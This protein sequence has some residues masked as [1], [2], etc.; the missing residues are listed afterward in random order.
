MEY[1]LNKIDP[2]LRRQVNEAAKEG[3][4]HGADHSLTVNKDRKQE[5]K[6]D[7]QKKLESKKRI[8]IDAENNEQIDLE[9]FTDEDISKISSKGTIL[10]TRK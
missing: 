8:V 5:Q 7:F 10:D 1:K 3:K 4:V 6:S 9:A 2:D